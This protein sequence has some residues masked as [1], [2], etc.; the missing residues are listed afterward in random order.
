METFS[1]FYY[2]MKMREKISAPTVYNGLHRMNTYSICYFFSL[3]LLS[4]KGSNG[5][6]R[7]SGWNQTDIVSNLTL[8]FSMSLTWSKLLNVAKP[9]FLC[10]SGFS[11]INLIKYVVSRPQDHVYQ[12][13]GLMSGIQH[14]FSTVGIINVNSCFSLKLFKYLL[15]FFLKVLF[16]F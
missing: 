15:N 2:S 9:Q 13:S 14:T 12:V 11:H 3:V 16:I 8:P 5:V 1:P 6:V 7:S 10:E 4:H